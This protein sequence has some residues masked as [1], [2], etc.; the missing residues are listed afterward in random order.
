MRNKYKYLFLRKRI[1]VASAQLHIS[2]P[3]PLPLP[4]DY[5]LHTISF[6]SIIAASAASLVFV[7][8]SEFALLR[9]FEVEARSCLSISTL[10]SVVPN[11]REFLVWKRQPHPF[12][13]VDDIARLQC[14]A[15]EMASAS[16]L[17]GEFG[18]VRF[19]FFFPYFEC[20]HVD[21]SDELL[22][23]GCCL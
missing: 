17:S 6:L 23:L 10:L 16:S 20:R 14:F 15:I 13:F 21:M 2:L 11:P 7:S 1:C 12:V 18:L 19:F 5:L 22:N 9:R 3:L 4:L 8:H